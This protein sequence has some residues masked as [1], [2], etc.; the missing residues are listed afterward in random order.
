ML[1]FYEGHA[2]RFVKRYADLGAVIVDALERYAD[3]VRSG[4]FPE[5]QHTYKMPP[6]ELERFARSSSPRR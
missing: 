5:D 4:A 3:E 2:P 6:E 1:G